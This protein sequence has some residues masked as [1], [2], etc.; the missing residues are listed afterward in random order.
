MKSIK[1]IKLTKTLNGGILFDNSN[2]ELLIIMA[3]DFSEKKWFS[4]F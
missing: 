2:I 3:S 1:N 4:V